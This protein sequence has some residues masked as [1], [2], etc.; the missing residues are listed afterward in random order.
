MAEKPTEQKQQKYKYKP[1][2]SLSCFEKYRNFQF[3]NEC[4]LDLT[5]DYICGNLNSPTLNYGYWYD[6][7]SYTTKSRI[8]LRYRKRRGENPVVKLG[9]C[10]CGEQVIDFLKNSNKKCNCDRGCASVYFNKVF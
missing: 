9:E 1:C 3:V 6:M 2:C 4:E 10:L 5:I 8:V 7:Y